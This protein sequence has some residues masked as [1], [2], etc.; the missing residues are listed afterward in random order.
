M[1][2]VEDHGYILDLGVS[3]VSGFL[4]FKEA[5]KTDSEGSRLSV[6][7]LIDVSIV[8][9]SSNGRSCTVINDSRVLASVSVGSLLT[10]AIHCAENPFKI[11][12]VMNVSSVLPGSLV[13]SMVTTVASDG[14]HLQILGFFD[15]TADEFHLPN[16]RKTLN[17][18]EKVKARVLYDLPGTTP[19]RFVVSLAEHH[20][21]LQPKSTS[22]DQ[23]LYTAF[24]VGAVLDPV[25]VRRVEA[26]RGLFVEIQPNQEGFVH[27]GI[28]E[29]GD[30][31]LID[32]V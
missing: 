6:G 30:S 19:P 3:G 4:Q 21:G 29:S 17:V 15:A 24:P 9:M 12:E 8:N 7:A 1:Q 18:G 20:I 2:S 13:Q 11:S 5:H 10:Y 28:F 22:E 25:K 31:I 16:G 14:L 26:E 27:V 23:P 32:R